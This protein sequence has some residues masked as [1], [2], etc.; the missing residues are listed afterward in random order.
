[1]DPWWLYL[2]VFVFG[3]LTHKT[4]YF[5]RSAKISIGL[6]RVSQLVSIA[7][8][9]KSM[10]NFYY[11]HT[12][13]LQHMKEHDES[14]KTIKDI[15]RS[16]NMEITNYKEKVIKEVLDLHPNFYNPII[17]FDNWKSAMKYLEK[18]KQFVLELLNQD[19]NDKKTS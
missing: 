1:M 8:L 4:F 12:S 6:I 3:Y 14:E 2:I 10:E 19:K 15:T 7:V 16:F 13:R 5:L 11:S 17:E 9:A 18:N